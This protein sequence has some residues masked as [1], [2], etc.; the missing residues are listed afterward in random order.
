MDLID[1]EQYKLLELFTFPRQFLSIRDIVL[2]T[3][4][5][6]TVV[7]PP[8]LHLYQAGYLAA[9]SGYIPE[10][11]DTIAVDTKLRRTY[12][13]EIAMRQFKQKTT[14]HFWSEF[15]AWFTL[16]IA[17]IALVVSIVALFM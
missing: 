9:V 16:G 4:E 14:V 3:N 12:E 17:L 10:G 7:G 11:E 1:K 8:I 13:A 2:I 15:R 6:D 5:P